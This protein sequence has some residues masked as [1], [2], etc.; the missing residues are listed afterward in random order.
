MAA[1]VAL[2]G[3]TSKTAAVAAKWTLESAGAQ[4]LEA[5]DGLAWRGPMRRT[6]GR[7]MTILVRT[8][9][10]VV[11]IWMI[12]I[13]HVGILQALS[14]RLGLALHAPFEWTCHGA[15]IGIG[16]RGAMADI[17]T[18]GALGAPCVPHHALHAVVAT[19]ATRADWTLHAP[20]VLYVI[21]YITLVSIILLV[22][23][24]SS[25]ICCH[26]VIPSYWCHT[27]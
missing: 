16:V 23:F 24:K 7:H 9:S 12:T 15:M 19:K 2:I 11:I 21:Y 27:C 14:I 20:I 5:G 10:G 25:Y 18:Q 26:Q 8:D 17:G 22:H 13:T 3:A 1:D 6:S 4:R